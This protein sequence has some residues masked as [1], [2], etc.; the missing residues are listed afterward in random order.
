MDEKVFQKKVL[1]WSHDVFGIDFKEDDFFLD[2]SFH[3]GDLT[4]FAFASSDIVDIRFLVF[5]DDAGNLLAGSIIGDK[6]KAVAVGSSP[7]VVTHVR[8]ALSGKFTEKSDVLV[9]YEKGATAAWWQKAKWAEL[10]LLFPFCFVFSFLMVKL[11]ARDVL[12]ESYPTILV[13]VFS[14]LASDFFAKRY[15]FG[16]FSDDAK[17][18]LAARTILTKANELTDSE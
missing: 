1:D 5:T 17:D 15:G 4:A 11:H 16:R 10:W 13:T 8:S 6:Q 14:V 9:R 12:G 3:V 2:S 7:S 18:E